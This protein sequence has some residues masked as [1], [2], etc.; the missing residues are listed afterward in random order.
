[1][2]PPGEDESSRMTQPELSPESNEKSGEV[3]VQEL[4]AQC[5][6]FIHIQLTQAKPKI[7]FFFLKS[8]N[9]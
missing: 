8:G 3:Y 7:T 2:A 5:A 4:A 1:M 6:Q 9:F